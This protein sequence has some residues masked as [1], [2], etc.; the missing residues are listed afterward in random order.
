MIEERGVSIQR[1]K[2]ALDI[3][4]QTLS[5]VFKEVLSSTAVP[6]SA[7]GFAAVLGPG[8]E[9]KAFSRTQTVRG[10]ASTL[11]LLLAND[12]ELDYER[13]LS[14]FPKKSDGKPLPLKKVAERASQLS[15]MCIKTMERRAAACVV[16]SKSHGDRGEFVSHS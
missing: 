2:G 15:Q 7:Q 4:T 1:T 14:D 10:S 12:V 6:S 5:A 13:I 9:M 8:T 3:S 11:Q 16:K